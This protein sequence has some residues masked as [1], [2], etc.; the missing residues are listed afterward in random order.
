MKIDSRH[1][2]RSFTRQFDALGC[3][4][5]RSSQP[6]GEGFDPALVATVAAAAACV[7]PN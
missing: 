6:K 1:E 2:H 4:R 5:D 7:R 3:H